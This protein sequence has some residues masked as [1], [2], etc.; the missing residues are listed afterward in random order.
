[1]GALDYLVSFNDFLE[2]VPINALEF[3]KKMFKAGE[4]YTQDFV[5]A[6]CRWIAWKINIMVERQRQN[7]IKKLAGQYSGAQKVA[8]GLNV[9][10]NA[11]SDPIGTIGSVFSWWVKPYATAV[12]FVKTLVKEI[13]RLTENLANIMNSLPP[14]PPNPRIN[15]NAFKLKINTITLADLAGSQMPTPEEMFPA[16]PSPFSKATF[17]SSFENAPVAEGTDEVMYKLDGDNSSAVEQAIKEATIAG[18]DIPK[19]FT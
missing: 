16:P 7:V 14:E 6:C 11:L 13:P 3:F 18:L 9:V 1:M 5:D 19:N 10:K 17:D 4:E 12:E 8:A 15:F 2:R